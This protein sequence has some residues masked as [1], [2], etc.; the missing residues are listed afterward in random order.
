MSMSASHSPAFEPTGPVATRERRRPS[1][2]LA[3]SAG[4]IFGLMM[5]GSVLA[6]TTP[7]R[8]HRLNVHSDPAEHE[9]FGCLAGEVWRCRYDKLPEPTLGL[10]WD[11]THGTFSGTDT[12]SDW[13][14]PAWFRG[15]ACDAADTVVSGVA[16]FFPPRHGDPDVVDQQLLVSDDG[17][18]WIYW[19]DLFVCPWYPTFAE[20]LVSESSCTFAP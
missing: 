18:L 7:M 1:I 12:T 11:Q 6:G 2:A 4:L 10:A 8:W 5:S 16:T 20:A 14:C 9:R 3:L 15:D 13:V 19:T 17:S